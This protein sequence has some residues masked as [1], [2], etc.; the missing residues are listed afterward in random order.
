[1]NQGQPPAVISELFLASPVTLLAI[2]FGPG[3]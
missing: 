2:L 1:M 3:R